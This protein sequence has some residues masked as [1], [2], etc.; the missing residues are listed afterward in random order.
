MEYFYFIASIYV[1]QPSVTVQPVQA[2]QSTI[3]QQP[4][5][6]QTIQSSTTSAVTTPKVHANNW[7]SFKKGPIRL[8][9][10]KLA[11]KPQQLH[12]CEVCKISC[13]GPQVIKTYVKF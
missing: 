11:P 10:P 7:M 4:Q 1:Q 5:Q 12:Y 2:A 9:R 13:A 6:V 8:N 3:V